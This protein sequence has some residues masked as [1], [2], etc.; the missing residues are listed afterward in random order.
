MD[1][2]FLWVGGVGGVG[3]GVYSH[4]RVQPPTTVE[5]RLSLSWGYDNT[6]FEQILPGQ[7]SL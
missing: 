6:S 7:I 5:V 1:I 2:E 4:F 3:W